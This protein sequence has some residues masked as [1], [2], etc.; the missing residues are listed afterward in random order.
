MNFWRYR[1]WI[2]FSGIILFGLR[3]VSVTVIGYN[4]KARA[5]GYLQDTYE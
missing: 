1:A 3:V 4:G 5:T 2:G